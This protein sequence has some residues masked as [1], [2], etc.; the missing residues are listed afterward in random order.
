MLSTLH[1]ASRLQSPLQC[2]CSITRNWQDM[3]YSSLAFI[4][5]AVGFAL[6]VCE[7]F[8]PSGGMITVMCVISFVISVWMAYR[9]WWNSSPGLF[10]SFVSGLL[11]VI[12]VFV[13]G[14]FRVIENTRLG[15]RILLTGPALDE[16]T[17]Y[18]AEEQHL[19]TLIGRHG[20]TQSMLNP[21]G[22]IKVDGERLHAIS[23]GMVIDPDESVEII[24]VRGTRV[25]VRRGAPTTEMKPTR[26]P[27][28]LASSSH[29]P[30]D[31]SAESA[32]P[33]QLDFDMPQ[34]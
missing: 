11:V 18:Q 14:V 30:V 16:V 31:E 12:P 33:A 27:E 2:R 10:W 25:I 8:I 17:P 28:S 7:V 15:D 23:E 9:G 29:I 22:F 5:A 21:G 20:R 26:T 32:P 3:D 13:L 6:I 1:R 4:F 34:G 24:G 19:T